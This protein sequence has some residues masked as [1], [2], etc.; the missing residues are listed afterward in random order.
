MLWHKIMYCGKAMPGGVVCIGRLRSGYG[1]KWRCY[2]VG[3]VNADRYVDMPPLEWSRGT[4]SMK[5]SKLGGADYG[6]LASEDSVRDYDRDLLWQRRRKSE[7]SYFVNGCAAAQTAHPRRLRRRRRLW[8]LRPAS[9]ETPMTVSDPG[10]V[11]EAWRTLS[12]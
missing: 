3:A 1:Y 7:V 4:V 10:R 5:G 9:L 11:F 6:R 8:S 2:T 12:G